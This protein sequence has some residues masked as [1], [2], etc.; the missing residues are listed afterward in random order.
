VPVVKLG[1]CRWLQRR[2]SSDELWARIEPVLPKVERRFRDPGRKRL[3]I[4]RHKCP[5]PEHGVGLVEVP[6]GRRTLRVVEVR[7][8]DLNVG[9]DAVLVVEDMAG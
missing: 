2:G 3:P 6:L 5:A 9:R 8:G 1:G 7:D 4:G